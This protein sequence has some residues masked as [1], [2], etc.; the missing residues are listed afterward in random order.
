M[1]AGRSPSLIPIRLVVP[2]KGLVAN[3]P[4]NE[5]PMDSV[6]SG[7]NMTIDQDGLYSVRPGYTAYLSDPPIDAKPSDAATTGSQFRL[8]GGQ[9]HFNLDPQA[10]GMSV[11]KWELIATLSDGSRHSVWIQIK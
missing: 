9:W 8:T 6:V 1:S 5:A 3:L 11:G 2:R 4:T 7:S 10:T